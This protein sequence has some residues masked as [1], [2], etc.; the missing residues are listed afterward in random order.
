MPDDGRVIWIDHRVSRVGFAVIKG[1]RH[2]ELPAIDLAPYGPVG[3]RRFCL[4]DETARRA[5]RTVENPS[6][7][8]VSAQLDD[9]GLR[10]TFPDG[11]S[12]AAEVTPTGRTISFDYWGR[13]VTGTVLDGPWATA[14]GCYLGREVIMVECAPGDVVF[15]GQVTMI[16]SSSL[17]TIGELLGESVDPA[18]LRATM[19]I[20]DASTTEDL[21][22]PYEA[23]W[24]GRRLRIGAAEVVVDAPIARCAVIDIDPRSGVRS[25]APLLKTLARTAKR[26]DT[27]GDPIFGVQGTVVRPGAVRPGDPVTPQ[28]R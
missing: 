12:V 14:F 25:S 24:L 3:D 28:P 7:V 20:D 11:S 23:G 22:Q 9:H 26:D 2:R 18:R 15:G 1:T 4:V 8:A 5:L 19:V 6:L 16:T 27:F 21:Q 17:R 10:C 13:T